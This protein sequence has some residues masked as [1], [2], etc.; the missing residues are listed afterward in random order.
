MA[1]PNH[2]EVSQRHVGTVVLYN[3]ELGND[4]K[5]NSRGIVALLQIT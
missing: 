1:P 4:A 5:S 3:L 2:Q